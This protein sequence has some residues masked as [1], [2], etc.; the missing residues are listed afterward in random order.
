VDITFFQAFL[1]SL[2][3]LDRPFGNCVVK[4]PWS[5]S[6]GNDKYQ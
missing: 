1:Q 5:G 4:M 6:T 3:L 2:L